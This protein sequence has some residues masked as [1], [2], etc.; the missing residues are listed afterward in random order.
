MKGGLIGIA[1]NKGAVHRWLMS[2]AERSAM[3][4]INEVTR[5]NNRS[6][7][8]FNGYF[9]FMCL[10]QT[11]CPFRS[12]KDLDKTRVEADEKSVKDAV[13]TVETMINPFEQT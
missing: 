8:C 2:G 9:K 1:L 7:L 11:V 5:H 3:A 13:K 6:Y 12:R 4:N 10:N